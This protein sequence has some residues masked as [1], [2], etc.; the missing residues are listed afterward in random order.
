MTL[1]AWFQSITASVGLFMYATYS[2][3]QSADQKHFMKTPNLNMKVGKKHSTF[4]GKTIVMGN[5]YFRIF[6]ILNK[7]SN[8]FYNKYCSDLRRKQNR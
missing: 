6:K 5:I 1:P 7:T 2:E 4:L 3:K 8:F